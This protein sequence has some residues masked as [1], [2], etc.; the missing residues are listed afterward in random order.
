MKKFYAHSMDFK[1]MTNTRAGKILQ[2]VPKYSRL[3]L[4]IISN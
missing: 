4:D 3:G 2:R 1:R